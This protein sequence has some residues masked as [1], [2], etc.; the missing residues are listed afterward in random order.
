MKNH[1][2]AQW[3]LYILRTASGLLYTGIT[4]DIDR[5]FNQH[6]NGKGAKALRGK[7]PLELLFH[8]EAGD[9]ANAS[10]LEY[11]VKQLRRLD[12]IRLIAHQPDSLALWLDTLKNG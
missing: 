7:G 4:N 3:R 10:K 8:C 6:Q 11:Q 2:E 12:K 5:R 1:G 9:R